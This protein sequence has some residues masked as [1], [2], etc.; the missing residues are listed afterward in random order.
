MELVP[1]EPVRCNLVRVRPVLGELCFRAFDHPLLF[2][3]LVLELGQL[4]RAL[5]WRPARARAFFGLG[6]GR[7]CS[8]ALSRSARAS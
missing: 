3:D 2:L 5:A 8:S 4:L 7:G 1:R 6:G